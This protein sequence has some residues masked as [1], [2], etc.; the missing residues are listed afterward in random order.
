MKF[1][2]SKQQ[3][4]EC[5][6]QTKERFKTKVWTACGFS[7]PPW[8]GACGGTYRFISL[9]CFSNFEHRLRWLPL[10]EIW[11]ISKSYVHLLN[12][13]KN[14]HQ[15]DK[16]MTFLKIHSLYLNLF[17]LFFFDILKGLFIC[18]LLFKINVTHLFQF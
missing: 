5:G 17:D 7:N 14:K 12:C 10:Q 3:N 9:R 11:L 2:K 1:P 16:T 4:R 15:N 13:I 6:S 8:R 18:C